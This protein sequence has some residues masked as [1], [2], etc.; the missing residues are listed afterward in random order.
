M[1]VV[2]VDAVVAVVLVVALVLLL[3]LL[4]VGVLVVVSVVAVAVVAGADDEAV[5]A[6]LLMR[7]LR[8]YGIALGLL[9]PVPLP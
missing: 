6:T 1:F 8:A 4:L 5:S 9:V 3:V 7:A 2:A